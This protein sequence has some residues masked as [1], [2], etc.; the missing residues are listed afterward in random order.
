MGK[1]GEIGASQGVPEAAH[2]KSMR[3]VQGPQSNAVYIDPHLTLSSGFHS[4]HQLYCFSICIIDGYLL[5]LP[6]CFTN[7]FLPR[8]FEKVFFPDQQAR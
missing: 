8:S 1:V 2:G 6:R 5:L 3:L 4:Q 7:C